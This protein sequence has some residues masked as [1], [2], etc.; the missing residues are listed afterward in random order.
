VRT[1]SIGF[2]DVSFD[3][4]SHARR[5]LATSAQSTAKNASMRARLLDVPARGVSTSSTNP[6]PT[7]R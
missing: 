4:S 3:E 5:V 7:L 1:F 6:W 2:S